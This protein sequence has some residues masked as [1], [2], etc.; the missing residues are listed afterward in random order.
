MATPADP[1]SILN[2]DPNRGKIVP[3]KFVKV[4]RLWPGKAPQWAE[5]EQ[6]EENPDVTDKAELGKE[7]P[8]RRKFQTEIIVEA[9]PVSERID[10]SIPTNKEEDEANIER[11]RIKQQFLQ[12]EEMEEPDA[13]P[14]VP[15]NLPPEP[16]APEENISEPANEVMEEE[17]SEDSS[18]HE[19]KPLLKP[20]FVSKDERVTLKEKEKKEQEE[21][22]R[23]E[24]EK[25]RKEELK[26]ETKMMIIKAVS[27]FIC[28][29]IILDQ[30]RQGKAGSCRGSAKSS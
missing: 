20:M 29:T 7:V 23:L 9:A 2:K 27:L 16:A 22:A 10:V 3:K 19:Q 4:K 13:F 30:R 21:Q 26:M 6:P 14:D 18:I 28:L 25:K 12:N 1:H 8:G 17:A 24:E 15:E 5:G 11:E